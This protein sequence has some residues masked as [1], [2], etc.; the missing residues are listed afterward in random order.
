MTIPSS[1]QGKDEQKVDTTT[2]NLAILRRKLEG[3]E[4]AK[5]AAEAKNAAYE[6]EIA[7]ASKKKFKDVDPDEDSYDEPYVDERRL[8]KKLERFEERFTKKV[9]EVADHRARQMVE[10]ERNSQ[11][12][13]Q[14]P[15]FSQILSPEIIEKFAQKHPEIAE[16]MLEMPEG[17]ARQKLLYQNIKALGIHKPAVAAPSIQE[18]IDKNRKSP[19]YQPTGVNAG[20]YS[21]GGDFS[22]AG[23]KGAYEKVQELKARL[24]L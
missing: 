1:E 14:N 16:P 9:D 2:E 4:R 15:D 3:A 8:N 5:A 19:F 20:P 13:K 6:K 23:Q 10:Q 21:G 17:F 12:L 24:R 22:A 11:F 7:E 18:T